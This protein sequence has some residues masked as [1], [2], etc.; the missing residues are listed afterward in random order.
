MTK[1][2]P[3]RSPSPVAA[4]STTASGGDLSSDDDFDSEGQR[5]R[6]GVH[7]VWELI[8]LVAAMGAVFLLSQTSLGPFGAW[9][10]HGLF[11]VL[12]P[13]LLAATAAA[14]SLRVG[15]ANFAVGPI[16]LLAGWLFLDASSLGLAAVLL[17]LASAGLAGLMLA[18]LVAWLRI[19]AW[20]ASLTIGMAIG[21]WW[22][23]A[24]APGPLQFSQFPRSV[25]LLAVGA[26]IGFSIMLGLIGAASKLREKLSDIRDAAPGQKHGRGKLVFVGLLASSLLAGAAGVA[27]AWISPHFNDGASVP[28]DGM[29]YTLL[30]MAAALLGGTSLFGRRG[31]FAGTAL[32]TTVLVSTMWFLES[33]NEN[34]DEKWLLVA[35]L[36]AGFIISRVIETFNLPAEDDDDDRDLSDLGG[37]AQDDNGEFER[38][39]AEEIPAQRDSGRPFDGTGYDDDFASVAGGGGYGPQGDPGRFGP[40]SGHGGY[41]H[42]T[43]PGANEYGEP[44]YD[45][46][47]YPEPGTRG[48]YGPRG[49]SADTYPPNQRGFDDPGY[50]ANGGYGNYRR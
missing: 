12:T 39:A 6:L 30:P 13:F 41:G 16:A 17:G 49:Y 25:A 21:L 14:I 50:D 24:G 29:N 42:G 23:S 9:G 37:L 40:Q 20:A 36:F 48:G 43:Q 7:I 2:A 1:K 22:L 11:L 18:T 28:A 47:G 38:V 27:A 32:A 5:D 4:P 10:W 45:N 44:G 33:R 19:P 46:G 31:G 15:S 34:F 26:A 3:P 35:A 8:L